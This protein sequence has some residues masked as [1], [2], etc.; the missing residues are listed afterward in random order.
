VLVLDEAV[1]ALA[2]MYRRDVLVINDEDDVRKGN[3]HQAYRQ[4]VLWY[5]GRLIPACCVWR[6]RDKFP[7]A[8]GQ[9]K[10]FIPSRLA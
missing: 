1:L 3:R 10:G 5:H 9:Y 6:I 2:R 7:D 8:F 4:F